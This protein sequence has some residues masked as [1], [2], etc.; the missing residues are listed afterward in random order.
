M[1]KGWLPKSVRENAEVQQNFSDKPKESTT[2][3]QKPLGKLITLEQ[4]L[5]KPKYQPKKRALNRKRICEVCGKYPC[6]NRALKCLRCLIAHA[7]KRGDSDKV[8]RLT[9][10]LE[11]MEGLRIERNDNQKSL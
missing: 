11:R 1:A 2:L 8:K 6:Y 7:E 9:K 3:N 4:R 5:S 10:V